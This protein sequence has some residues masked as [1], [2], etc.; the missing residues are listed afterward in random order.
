MFNNNSVY[1]S[2]YA[3]GSTC[4]IN[5]QSGCILVTNFAEQQASNECQN[6]FV[7]EQLIQANNK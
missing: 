1:D 7:Q 3:K 6:M 4:R 2:G 5:D